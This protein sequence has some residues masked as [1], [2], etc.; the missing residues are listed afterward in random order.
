MERERAP[1]EARRLTTGA[2]GGAETRGRHLL[3]PGAL[4][5]RE[6]C[7]QYHPCAEERQ[8]PLAPDS[9]PRIRSD[10]GR[11][12]AACCSILKIKNSSNERNRA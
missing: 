9:N 7:N 10:S 8:P 12:R 5:F 3:I 2:I 1:L 6:R 4:S 11:I